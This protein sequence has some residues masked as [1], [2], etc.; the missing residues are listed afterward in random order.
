[1]LLERLVSS[2]GNLLLDGDFNFHVN[3]PSDSN[4]S[5]FLDLLNWFN[6]DIFNLCAPRHKNNNVLDLIITRSGET[7]VLNLSVH[8]PVISDHFAAHCNLAI[9]KPHNA[10]LIVMTRKLCSIDSNS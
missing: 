7:S 6:L 1:M 4:E 8:A 2:P 10:K 3:D 5:Q 9:K